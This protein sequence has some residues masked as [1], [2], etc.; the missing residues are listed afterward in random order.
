[1][2]HVT[3]TVLYIFFK[4]L[5][6]VDDLEQAVTVTNISLISATNSCEVNNT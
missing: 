3:I 5:D 6:I 2:Y 1:V 4:V